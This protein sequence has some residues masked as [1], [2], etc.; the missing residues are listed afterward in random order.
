MVDSAGIESFEFDELVARYHQEMVGLAYGMCGD[1]AI[2]EE[3]AQ[4]CWQAAWQAR[5]G[6][7]RDDVRGWL[8]TV[9]ANTTRRALRRER[10]RRLLQGRWLGD[11]HEGEVVP[12][13]HADLHEALGRLKWSDRQLLILRFGMGLTSE[14]A[15]KTLGL[16]AGALR[17]RQSRLLRRLRGDLGASR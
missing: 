1:P 10:M 17:A 4:A 12:L 7:R 14:E 11:R 2:A 16:S 15:A 13:E 6:L 9:T 5:E 3:A 8:F